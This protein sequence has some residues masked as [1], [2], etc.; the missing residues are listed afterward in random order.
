MAFASLGLTDMPPTPTMIIGIVVLPVGVLVYENWRLTRMPHRSGYHGAG[1]SGSY[2]KR[3]PWQELSLWIRALRVSMLTC[4]AVGII[5]FSTVGAIETAALR[6]PKIA[7]APFVHPHEIK[8]GIRFFTDRQERIYAVGKPWMIGS[9]AVTLALM[10]ALG[11]IE[12][13]WRK[14]KQQDL[15]DRLATEV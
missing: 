15:L 7:D 10:L 5:S 8:G 4:W 12:E 6:Q 13:S 2:P 1:L 14:R 3:R 9:W 11:H